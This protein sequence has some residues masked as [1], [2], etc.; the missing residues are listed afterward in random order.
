MQQNLPPRNKCISF[1]PCYQFVPKLPQRRLSL[2]YMSSGYFWLRSG[3]TFPPQAF[4]VVVAIH[5]RTHRNYSNFVLGNAQVLPVYPIVYCSDGFCELTG[6]A[7]AQIMQKGCACKFLYGPETDEEHKGQIEK[8][9]ES[10]TE[11]KMEVM[12]Y[13][14]N[15]SLTFGDTP[16]K[17]LSPSDEERRLRKTLPA[18]LWPYLEEGRKTADT[19]REILT[20]TKWS[21]SS[22]SDQEILIKSAENSKTGWN[23]FY[24]EMEL[25]IPPYVLFRSDWDTVPEITKWNPLVLESSVP[26]DL[27]PHCRITHQV[28]AP[29]ANGLIWSREIVAVACWEKEGDTIY[30]SYSSVEAMLYPQGF[31]YAPLAG[32][33]NK[34]LL[35]WIYH[36]DLRLAFVPT[37]ILNIRTPSCVLCFWLLEFDE[38]KCSTAFLDRGAVLQY[39]T[40]ALTVP[41]DEETPD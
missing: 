20:T 15:E 37:A 41:V 12:F 4:L 27:T 24:L 7:R 21:S 23:M 18:D 25:D 13:K 2:A 5:H 33:P 1:S 30:S 28:S 31:V 6:W 35:T 10:K 40:N 16:S 29:I 22:F 34:T 32:N 26:L 11:L 38:L 17:L 14:K 3:W 19:F 39:M 8:A 36:T 9:L